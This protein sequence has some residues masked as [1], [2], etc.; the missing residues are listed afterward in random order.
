MIRIRTKVYLFNVVFF[1]ACILAF[2]MSGCSP[3]DG[4]QVPTATA[5]AEPTA[6]ILS[7]KLEVS[8]TP[9]PACTVTTGIPDGYLNLRKGPGTNRAV[10]RVL[11]EGEILQVIARGAWLKVVTRE[12]LT[13]FVNSKFCK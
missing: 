9:Q 1:V 13:G 7:T 12:K 4:L 2:I 5:T 11:R 10:I 6:T 3:F 8:P